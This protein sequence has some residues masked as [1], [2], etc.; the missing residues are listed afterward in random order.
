MYL[1]P[2]TRTAERRGSSLAIWMIAVDMTGR[3][4]GRVASPS[5]GETRARIFHKPGRELFVHLGSRRK[6]LMRSDENRSRPSGA[7]ASWTWVVTPVTHIAIATPPP[8]VEGSLWGGLNCRSAEVYG[9]SAQ[10]R[11]EEAKGER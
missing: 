4:L 5:D 2:F 10:Y 6:K 8:A 11:I 7:F 9:N 1:L 3:I